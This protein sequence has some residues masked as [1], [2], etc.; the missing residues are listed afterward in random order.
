MADGAQ[1]SKDGRADVSSIPQSQKNH[2]EPQRTSGG[3]TKATAAAGAPVAS[4]QSAAQFLRD[5]ILNQLMKLICL[6]WM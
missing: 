6:A 2:A 5:G 4:S 1:C 3:A